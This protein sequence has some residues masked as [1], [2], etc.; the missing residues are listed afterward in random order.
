L[1]VIIAIS[2]SGPGTPAATILGI[3]T[4]AQ[5]TVT[6]TFR[7]AGGVLSYRDFTSDSRS[8]YATTFTNCVGSLS[9]SILS[10]SSD[11][12]QGTAGSITVNISFPTYLAAAGL[13]AIL[14]INVVDV[15]LAVPLSGALVH[16]ATPA[17]PVNGVTPL[18]KIACSNVYQ[19]G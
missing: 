3:T 15:N 7:S 10:L 2:L 6:V 4:T 5:I 16:A 13:S 17:V 11:T 12:G 14:K 9:G 19:T 18:Q 8:L 1:I